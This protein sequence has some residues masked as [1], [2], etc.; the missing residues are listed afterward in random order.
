MGIARVEM[1]ASEVDAR[2]HIQTLLSS[3]AAEGPRT[4]WTQ[5]DYPSPQRVINLSTVSPH[6]PPS[7]VLV[8]TTTAWGLCS[9]V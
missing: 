7:G 5:F 3:G 6:I 8:S 2:Q 9:S 1:F 4:D